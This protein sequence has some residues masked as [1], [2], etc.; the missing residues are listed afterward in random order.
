MPSPC[1]CILSE[2]GAL[3]GGGSSSIFIFPFVESRHCGEQS[4]PRGMCP[5]GAESKG[6]KKDI[7]PKAKTKEPLVYFV[8][9][10]Q[11][12]KMIVLSET[13]LYDVIMLNTLTLHICQNPKNLTAQKVNQCMHIKKKKK[14]FY[15]K[16]G[17]QNLTKQSNYITNV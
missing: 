13:I 3:L 14:H 4:R 16:N 10:T 11:F 6:G 2:P 1:Q 17:M 15:I 9:P 5:C 8:W 12:L 7:K